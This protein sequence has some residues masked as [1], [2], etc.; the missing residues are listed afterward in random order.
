[1]NTT[2]AIFT[3]L[4]SDLS[5]IERL[6]LYQGQP[7]IFSD[8]AP[9]DFTFASL[10]VAVIAAPTSDSPDDT[11]TEDGRAITQ[12]VRLYARH[13]GSTAEIDQLARDVRDLFHQRP[14]ALAAA[15]AT[16]ITAIATG[17]VA[18]PTTDPSLVGRR[19]TL[20]FEL[21]RI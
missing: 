8:S 12:D 14:E 7:A 15:G 3:R 4:A 2:A 10:I 21:Q 18:S 19:I 6:D 1:M 13:T 11:F 20:R 9:D 5:T 16:F 17:P